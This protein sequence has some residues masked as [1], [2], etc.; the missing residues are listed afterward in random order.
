MREFLKSAVGLAAMGTVADV[1][2]LV[3]ENRILVRYG[4]ATLVEKSSY[5]L[6]MLLKVAELDQEPSLSAEDIGFGLAPRLNAAGRLGQARLAVELL[7]TDNRERAIQLAAYIDELNKNRQ[8][9]E[10]RMTKEATEQIEK[11]NWQDRGA[12][13]L[14]DEEWHPGVIGIVAGR[15]AEK[16]EKPTIVIAISSREEAGASDGTLFSC[17]AP[18][19]AIG[20]GSGRS[21]ANFDLHGGLTQCSKYLIAFGGHRVAAGLRIHAEE[22]E[23]FREAFIQHVEA[24]HTLKAQDT[25][26]SIDAEISLADL[27]NRAV[28]ELERLG[29][30]GSE[31]DRPVFAATGIRLAEPPHKMGQGERHLSLKVKQSNKT[32][33]A[34]AFG[35]AEWADEMSKCT[36]PISLCFAPI[37][38][39]FRGYEN[40]ELQL[41]DWQPDNPVPVA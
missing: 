39:R 9:I 30:F 27:T 26:I 24:N 35:R 36:G 8:T 28:R 29:P 40:V 15:L 7:T 32:M 34:I 3:G 20:Q 17:D 25:E 21:F 38:N 31:H 23:K 4:L 1:V 41:I 18:L 19:R 5:G 37:I 10:R 33:R 22:I 2:P 12:L 14:A 13:V 16:Y 6:Q 11:H